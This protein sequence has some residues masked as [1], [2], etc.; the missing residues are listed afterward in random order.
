MILNR[1]CTPGF[2]CINLGENEELVHKEEEEEKEVKDKMAEFFQ[3]ATSIL[4]QRAGRDSGGFL[5]ET[6]TILIRGRCWV[7]CDSVK[8]WP[9]GEPLLKMRA[10]KSV[11]NT[12]RHVG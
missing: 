9:C 3:P 4:P 6:H 10:P 5:C 12:W 2:L 7:L 1:D 8:L 11:R